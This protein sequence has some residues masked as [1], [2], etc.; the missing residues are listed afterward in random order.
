M[1]IFAAMAAKAIDLGPSAWAVRSS[2]GM[3]GARLAEAAEGATTATKLV[4][5]FRFG[6]RLFRTDSGC[7]EDS[8]VS[9]QITRDI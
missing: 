4:T 6:F 3:N 5:L 1:V 8:L 7:R 2:S 9:D